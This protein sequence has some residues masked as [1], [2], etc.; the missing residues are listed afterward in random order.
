[1]DTVIYDYKG[2]VYRIKGDPENRIFDSYDEAK[3]ASQKDE[4][5]SSSESPKVIPKKVPTSNLNDPKYVKSEF[6]KLLRHVE[7]LP[8]KS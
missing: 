3:E 7:G 6:E 2:R 4:V 5:E 8:W 1:M